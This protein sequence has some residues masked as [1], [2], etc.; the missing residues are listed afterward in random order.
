MCCTARTYTPTSP[1]DALCS[2]FRQAQPR[3][4]NAV[5]PYLD[6][7]GALAAAEVRYVVVG[8]VAVA[9]HGYLRAT[10]DLDIVIDLV[11]DNVRKAVDALTALGLRPRL[12]VAAM[13]FA[14]DEIRRS[15]VTERNLM[16]FSMW[17]PENPAI[18]V[19]LFAA[20]PIAPAELLADAKW[21]P[22]GDIQV[23]VVSRAH[24]IRLKKLAGRAQDIA[25]IEALSEEPDG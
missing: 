10:V 9:L 25:D 13:D 8:G 19:D 18:E 7:L 15:W 17:H 24:L 5:H 12:P 1:G 3:T 4:L 21:M 22:L 20:P 14:D 6:V 23:P 16:V 11:P 2:S